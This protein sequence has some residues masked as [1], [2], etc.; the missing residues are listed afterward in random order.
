MFPISNEVDGR[1]PGGLRK[2]VIL[3][4]L[5][6]LGITP[7]CGGGGGSSESNGTPPPG[8]GPAPSAKTLIW[9]AP[10]YYTDNTPLNPLT[11]LS[12]YEIYVNQSGTFTGADIPNDNVLAVNSLTNTPN[13]SYNLFTLGPSLSSGIVYRVSVRAVAVTGEKS[14]FATPVSFSF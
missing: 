2:I 11:D 4:A 3:L 1:L 6:L 9:T 10:L 5:V 12:R 7:G 14:D 8:G 13:T